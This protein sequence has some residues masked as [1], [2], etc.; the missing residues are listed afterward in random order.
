MERQQPLDIEGCAKCTHCRIGEAS[1]PGPV[2]YVRPTGVDLEAIRLISPATSLIQRRT[3]ERFCSWLE[4]SLSAASLEIIQESPH[5]QVHFLRTYGNFLYQQG[6][7]MYLFR[8]L[9]VYLQQMFP[10]ERPAV[11]PA[12]EL[13]ARWEAVQPVTHR[14]PLPK[15]IL[16]SMTALA[17]S[18]G[19]LRWAALTNLA[20]YGAMRV[21]EP[22]KA[23][24]NDL[25]LPS[26]AGLPADTCF[27]QVGAPKPGRRGRGRV[28]HARINDQLTVDLAVAAFGSLEPGAML[29]PVAP[30]TYRRRWDHLL[31][32]LGVPKSAAL[33][34]GSLRGGGACHMYHQSLPVSGI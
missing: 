14:P 17:L 24:R 11:A 15:P 16:E 9:V 32:I 18:W 33:T 30:A 2:R 27:L 31:G 10:S 23:K 25:L 19:W 34:P 29:Y 4:A 5:L 8:H 21:G 1:H 28:Q 12:W 26:D 3:R 7:P 13:L 22:L 20:F 6:Q